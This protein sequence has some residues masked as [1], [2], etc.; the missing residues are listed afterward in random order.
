MKKKKSGKSASNSSTG[1]SPSFTKK[2]VASKVKK[3]EVVQKENTEFKIDRIFEWFQDMK[4][5]DNEPSGSRSRSR[6]SS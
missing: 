5:K 6:S 2:K 3:A 4:R 1:S